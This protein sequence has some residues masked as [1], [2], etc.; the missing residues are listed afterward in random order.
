MEQF[1]TQFG[2]FIGIATAVIVGLIAFFGIW[3]RRS[4]ELK[5]EETE[6]ADSVINLLSKKVDVLEEKVEELE[7]KV[8]TLTK[9]NKT[10]RDVLQGR[11]E[12]TQQF[13]KDA[14]SAMEIIKH[15]DSISEENS[16][17]LAK[18]ATLLETVIKVK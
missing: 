2:G 10:L 4:K 18:I 11:D 1:I 14:Y 5:K 7:S 12:A 8:D 9:E 15:N 3:N 6:T 17:T 13:Y 16:R